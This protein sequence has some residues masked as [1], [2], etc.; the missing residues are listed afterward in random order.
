MHAVFPVQALSSKKQQVSSHRLNSHDVSREETK[1]RKEAEKL[2]AKAQKELQ[3][4]QQ[5]RD[6]GAEFAPRSPDR[7]PTLQM[8]PLI[9][10]PQPLL[11][12]RL[13]RS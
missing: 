10:D 4:L 9:I 11:V 5:K 3:K 7:R 1:R 2:E 6:T 12:V 13:E 8:F